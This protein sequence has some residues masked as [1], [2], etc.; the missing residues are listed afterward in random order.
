MTKFASWLFH[1]Y[2]RQRFKKK[3]PVWGKPPRAYQSGP[4]GKPE[5][6]VMTKKVVPTATPL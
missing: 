1:A 2:P 6:F 4:C 3:R 5:N